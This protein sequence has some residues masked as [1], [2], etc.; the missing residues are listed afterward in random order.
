MRYKIYDR[1]KK[2]SYIE[3]ILKNRGIDDPDH[4]MNLSWDDVQSPDDL[5]NIDEAV[6]L[7]SKHIKN[8]SRIEILVDTDLDG[9]CSSTMVYLALNRLNHVGQG[10]LV[11][12]LFHKNTKQHGLVN[13]DFNISHN[14]KLLIIPDAGTNDVEE[15]R[16]LK[17]SGIDVLILD[18]HEKDVENPYAVIV[19]PKAS[20]RYKNKE[21]CGAGVVYQF[22]RKIKK[23]K[24]VY[25]YDDI[26]AIANI[27]DVMDIR[28]Y[29][30]KFII[31]NGLKKTKNPFLRALFEYKKQFFKPNSMIRNIQMCICP[32]INPTIRIGD[33][34]DR[35]N[36]FY[37]LTSNDEVLHSD[38]IL[39]CEF[40]KEL[41]N[42][43]VDDILKNLDVPN[44]QVLLLQA[45]GVPEGLAG[46]LAAKLYN[47][48]NK[49]CIF[50]YVSNDGTCRGHARGDNHFRSKCQ[51]SGLFIQSIGHQG[52][53]GA[54]FNIND[55][56]NIRSY[57]NTN[58]M[59]EDEKIY[60]DFVSDTISPVCIR[61]YAETSQFVGHG[62]DPA[63]VLSG[64]IYVDSEQCKV[65]GKDKST[66]KISTYDGYQIMIFGYQ[67]YKNLAEYVKYNIPFVITE[68]VFEPNIN[69]YFGKRYFQAIVKYMECEEVEEDYEW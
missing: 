15:C 14:T 7:L 30:T 29:E 46:T 38:V 27:A 5:E 63:N 20:P 32:L 16:H 67:K 42:S 8:R 60:I 26:C 49:P 61:D 35:K 37:A 19:N 23:D 10:E 22:F 17:E 66:L 1:D 65:L 51:E 43:L 69:I 50:Y 47:I 58:S 24:K 64:G 2:L 68:I 34:E 44:D 45:D 40:Y 52:A 56:D 4:Y 55:I 54:Q 12:P 31:D 13:A 48:H 25:L 36:L 41:Q 53:F 57:F 62:I 3:Q 33:F 18:H 11:S 6:A 21:L 39:K 9:Y 28:S 59:T